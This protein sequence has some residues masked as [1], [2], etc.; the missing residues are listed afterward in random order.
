MRRG[1]WRTKVRFQYP[2]SKTWEPVNRRW[3]I[4]ATINDELIS[5]NLY[6]YFKDIPWSAHELTYQAL[7]GGFGADFGIQC[8]CS[9]RRLIE[10][11]HLSIESCGGIET[12][13]VGRKDGAY[14]G[15]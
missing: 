5:K 6:P 3:G 14:V 9:T 15:A 7:R 13:S 8:V 4:T 11:W 2:V 12:T 1:T 10:P